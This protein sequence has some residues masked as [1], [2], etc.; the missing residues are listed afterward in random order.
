MNHK[1]CVARGCALWAKILVGHQKGQISSVTDVY[2]FETIA[3]FTTPDDGLA[4]TV[5]VFRSGCQIDLT[6]GSTK[7]V[8]NFPASKYMTMVSGRALVWDDIR[9]GHP[10]SQV[11]LSPLSKPWS[12]LSMLF[13]KHVPV[14][15]SPLEVE[16]LNTSMTPSAVDFE[17]PKLHCAC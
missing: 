4:Q 3:H 16:H 15:E 9:G 1:E 8:L 6:S 2:S 12:F 13:F 17:I 5:Q 11:Q 7:A 10:R 14:S